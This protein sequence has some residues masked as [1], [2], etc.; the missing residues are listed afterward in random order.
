MN[1][2]S[3]WSVSPLDFDDENEEARREDGEQPVHNGPEEVVHA[4]GC[5]VVGIL[6]RSVQV[7]ECKR[8]EADHQDHEYDDAE[9]V[10]REIVHR[11]PGVGVL[12]SVS[13]NELEREHCERDIERPACDEPDEPGG[14]DSLRA[15]VAEQFE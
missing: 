13:E 2:L 6:D 12:A 11:A 1:V 10:V 8:G 4:S 9:P 15:V 7:Q 5:L 3:V 14:A